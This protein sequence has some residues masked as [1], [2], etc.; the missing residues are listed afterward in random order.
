MTSKRIW[1]WIGH[2][3]SKVIAEYEPM[4]FEQI[5]PKCSR[6]DR[7]T[8]DRLTEVK[9]SGIPLTLYQPIKY[10][11]S[12]IQSF[13]LRSCAAKQN[14]LNAK[15]SDRACFY[16]RFRLLREI[17]PKF[18]KQH[19][20]TSRTGPKFSG[21]PLAKISTNP[22]VIRRSELSHCLGCSTES[23]SL[24]NLEQQN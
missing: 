7:S 2:P 21:H 12:N 20:S 6:M 13:I 19:K 5:R 16:D 17:K 9:Y 23:Y 11:T 24:Y 1:P 8:R 3:T 15:F 18:N 4:P 14:S 22:L 10:C